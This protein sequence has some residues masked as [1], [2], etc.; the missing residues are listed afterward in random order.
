MTQQAEQRCP[1]LE[2]DHVKSCH[3]RI[4]RHIRHHARVKSAADFRGD[5]NGH[6][7]L[8]HIAQDHHQGQGAAEGAVK[9]GQSR[10]PAAVGTD[11][12][13]QDI[14]GDDD[15]AVE[16]AA[17][18]CNCGYQPQLHP[19]EEKPYHC[20]HVYSSFSPFCRIERIMGVPSRPKVLRMQFSRYLW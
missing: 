15:R 5:Q 3:L 1:V 9:I 2:Q 18:V 16:A 14:L 11:I 19:G 8:E 20:A 10:I 17:E 12:I 4:Q 13:P 6:H 7:C